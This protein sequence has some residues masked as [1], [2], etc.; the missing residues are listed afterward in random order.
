MMAKETFKLVV[1]QHLHKGR[2]F[3]LLLLLICCISQNSSHIVM[4]GWK[5]YTGYK[6][7]KLVLLSLPLVS[8]KMKIAFS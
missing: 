7:W 1:Y 3:R 4:V 2:G 6:V 8:E 5:W